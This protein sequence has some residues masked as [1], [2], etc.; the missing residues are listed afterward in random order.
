M[1]AVVDSLLVNVH[2]SGVERVLVVCPVNTLLNWRDEYEKW[3]P[4]N[5]RDYH[6][7]LMQCM[8][9]HLYFSQVFVLDDSPAKRHKKLM[10]WFRHGGV[11]LIG[12]EMYRSLAVG[13]RIKKKTVKEDYA[14]CLLDPGT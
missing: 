9:L 3:I 2:L 13:K 8:L 14:K 11:M 7:S 1:I 4:W 12:Y 10:R 6:V 5:D